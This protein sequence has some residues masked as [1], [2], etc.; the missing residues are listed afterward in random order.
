LIKARGRFREFLCLTAVW[1]VLFISLVFI[2][3]YYRAGVGAAMGVAAYAWICG[4]LT[5][6]VAIKPLGGTLRQVGEVLLAP[7]ALSILAIA[8][9]IAAGSLV[10]NWP[11]P[12]GQ[13]CR[14]IAVTTLAAGVYVPLIRRAQPASCDDLAA[15]FKGML[16]RTAN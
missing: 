1:A 7:V 14:M 15:K 8:I 12:W 6:Y 9:A 10:P 3:A 16:K 2:G 5:V 11:K 4:P 13:I